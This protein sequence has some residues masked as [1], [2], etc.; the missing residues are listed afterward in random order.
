[1]TSRST[2]EGPGDLAR[3]LRSLLDPMEPWITDAEADERTWSVVSPIQRHRVGEDADVILRRR[4]A[5]LLGAPAAE[6]RVGRS[7]GRC[8]SAAHG[9]PWARAIGRRDEVGVSLSRCGPH[10]LTAVSGTAR[11]GV[12][13]ESVAAV[14]AGWDPGLVLHPSESGHAS[15]AQ[16]RAAMWCRKEAI[17][18]LLGDG[19][20]T[21]MSSIRVADFEVVDVPAPQGY[22]AAYALQ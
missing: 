12:D 8:G 13:I 1:M 5:E 21:P 6:V 2:S 14:A 10:L 11:I 20:D 3:P 22:C 7:C 17:L 9:R 18:K 16:E 4:V 15:T 19:L